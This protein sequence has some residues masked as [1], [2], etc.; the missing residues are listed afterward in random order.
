MPEKVLRIFFL[1]SCSVMGG[2]WAKWFVT[3]FNETA[4]VPVYP[5][6]WIAFGAFLGMVI[7][8][9][10]VPGSFV[11]KTDWSVAEAIISANQGMIASTILGLILSGLYISLYRWISPMLPAWLSTKT[12]TLT[13]KDLRLP[14][15]LAVISVILGLII[16]R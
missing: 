5:S 16:I 13:W 14:A 11:Y 9:V 6:P 7:A 15:V 1:L 4:R 3:A 2:V 12:V 8:Y 10:F